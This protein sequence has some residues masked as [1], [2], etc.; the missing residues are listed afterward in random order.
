MVAKNKS[1]KELSQA[2]KAMTE[3]HTEMITLKQKIEKEVALQ[4]QID[5]DIRQV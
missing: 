3:A 4:K 5:L 1:K 2:K